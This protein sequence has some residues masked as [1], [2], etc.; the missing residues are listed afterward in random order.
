MLPNWIWR[1]VEK[2]Y[3]FFPTSEIEMTPADVGLD[4]EDVFFPT[5]NGNLLHGWYVPGSGNGTWL[6]F[7][8]NGGN[9]GHRV[10]ELALIHQRMGVDLLI[11]D[12]Q[13]YGR[14]QGRPSEVGTYQDARAAL[15][16]L[17]QHHGQNPGPVVYYGHS[18]GT[19]I[20]V[21][22][23]VE[24]PPVGLVLVSPFTSVSDMSGRAFP[25][26]PVSWLLKD[27]YN[28]LGRI[29]NVRSPL[30]ILH[31]TEDELVPV[32]H[33][34]K[35]FQAAAEPKSFQALP[36]TGHNDTFQAGG[37]AYWSAIEAFVAA[38]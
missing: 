13:G 2:R 22:L 35:L 6:W 9:V 14:S 8:G 19:A 17:Q 30:L 34:E 3:V 37:E 5:T 12:Y 20:A 15:D 16:Y 7:H 32:A 23:A 18:L 33:G 10:T 29:P 24:H 4:Y 21:E 1:R 25:W 28:S 36:Q 26:L 27:K 11:F 38:L 31:G